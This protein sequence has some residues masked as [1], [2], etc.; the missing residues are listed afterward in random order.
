[1][2]DSFR[3]MFSNN[4]DKTNELLEKIEKDNKKREF[5]YEENEFGVVFVDI[6]TPN[7][8]LTHLAA[9][10][11][12]GK[13][14]LETNITTIDQFQRIANHV[15]KYISMG[16]ES[17]ME[18]TNVVI[19]FDT[20]EIDEDILELFSNMKYCN[21]VCRGK[22]I[23]V[24]GSIRAY[25]NILRETNMN[26]K[27]YILFKY[28]ISNSIESE[29]LSSAFDEGLL[30]ENECNFRPSF[31]TKINEEEGIVDIEPYDISPIK[32]SDNVYIAYEQNISKIYDD[33][34][35]YGFTMRDIMKVS[36]ISIIFTNISRSC[37][38]Q[39][40]RHRNAV[41][42]ESQRYVEHTCTKND[43]VDPI[44]LNPDRYK[45]IDIPSIM[46]DIEDPLSNYSKLISKGI[47]KED[48]RAWLPMN[49]TTKLIMTFTFYNL[50]YFIN[51]RSHKSAQTEVRILSDVIKNHVYHKYGESLF[52][53]CLTHKAIIEKEEHDDEIYRSVELYS[54]DKEDAVDEDMGTETEEK[55][56]KEP[57]T[58]K[59]NPQSLNIKSL[60]DAKEY[61]QKAMNK[62]E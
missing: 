48:A 49:V 25:L 35:E 60:D 12:V 47:I 26:N 34:K 14:P 33:I 37:A 56:V 28:I 18:H 7:I 38:N 16:H 46:K 58:S 53:S 45:D 8:F 59:S 27:F 31:K 54:Y 55:E 6:S 15:D 36:I 5:S 21:V 39:I 44:N 51:L 41:S 43:F 23:L 17:I 20:D 42:Q 29:F 4:T 10:M 52:E 61:M 9:R 2:F 24:G 32:L 40:V 19:I 1:M 13:D 50:A 11:C 22:Y 3:R 62:N 57:K 30:E